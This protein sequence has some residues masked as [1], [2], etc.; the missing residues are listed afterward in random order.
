MRIYVYKCKSCKEELELPATGIPLK[1][2]V[3][4]GDMKRKFTPPAVII[5]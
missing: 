2:S 1:C 4:G 3:C 5:H